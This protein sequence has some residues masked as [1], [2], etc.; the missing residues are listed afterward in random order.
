[1][2]ALGEINGKLGILHA[3]LTQNSVFPYDVE[4]EGINGIS[5]ANNSSSDG[6][7][8]IL[9]DE[10]DK[11]IEV[12]VSAGKNFNTLTRVLKTID[13]GGTSTSYDIALY[14]EG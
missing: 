14:T 12:P 7:D 9:T 1:M 3:V 11:V 2:S 4:G 10:K 5:V 8:I 13:I 6:V